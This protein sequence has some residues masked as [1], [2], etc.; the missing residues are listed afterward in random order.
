[1]AFSPST[2]KFAIIH[3]EMQADNSGRHAERGGFGFEGA[4]AVLVAE[5][6]MGADEVVEGGGDDGAVARGVGGEQGRD[7]IADFIPGR[8]GLFETPRIRQRL[9]QAPEGLDAV[10]AIAFAVRLEKI[11][12]EF[13]GAAVGRDGFEAGSGLPVQLAEAVVAAGEEVEKRLLRS[14]SDK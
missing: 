9:A 4:G 11:A 5:D 3:F 13:G 2:V 14:R 6:A 1:M 12:P 8:D 10:G 7:E